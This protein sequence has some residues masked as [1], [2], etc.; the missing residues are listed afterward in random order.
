MIKLSSI[1]AGLLAGLISVLYLSQIFKWLIAKLFFINTSLFFTG[2]LPSIEIDY[3][4]F[5]LVGYIM[6]SLVPLLF[7]IITLELFTIL[8][9]KSGNEFARIGIIIFLLTNIGYLIVNTILGIA[10]VLL[11][12][13]FQTEWSSLVMNLRLTHNEKLILLL[14]MSI[15]LLIYLNYSAK[16]IKK[17]IPVITNI[18][19]N[20]D[21]QTTK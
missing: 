13:K 18:T 16:R 10:S 1:F 12:L 6:I 21:E 11:R 3:S 2:I 15:F 20:K 17:I 8:L 7:I 9:N 4:S 5:N 19:E 14:M